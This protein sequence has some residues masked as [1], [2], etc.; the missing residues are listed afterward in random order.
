MSKSLGNFL[1]IKDILKQYHP[2]A[3]RL[4]LLSK[5][6]R[7][8][9]DFSDQALNEAGAGLDKIYALLER[10]EKSAAGLP[11]KGS[12][13]EYW[14]RFCEAMDD[15]FN[16]AQGVG[17]LFDAVRSLNRLLD[18]NREPIS[19][20]L[21]QKVLSGREDLYKMGHILGILNEAPPAYFEKKQHQALR[22]QSVDP[23]Q[24]DQM[25]KERFEARKAKDWERADQIR[26]ALSE[27][28][29]ILED[30]PDGTIWKIKG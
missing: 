15:D 14:D 24:I 22:Q 10:A 16:T 4:F 8:P 5:H 29:I 25:V 12:S 30:H 6:Y 13:G 27:M 21:K 7:S 1:I 17:I 18:E 9:I 28:N 2:E 19:S 23:A 3:I 20:N 26:A 11:K